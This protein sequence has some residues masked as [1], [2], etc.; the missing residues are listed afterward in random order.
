MDVLR[1]DELPEETVQVVI[2]SHGQVYD[3]YCPLA[4]LQVLPA[5]V[6]AELF[7]AQVLARKPDDDAK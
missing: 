4:M 3:V 2:K 1:P 5:L 7:R 6:Q